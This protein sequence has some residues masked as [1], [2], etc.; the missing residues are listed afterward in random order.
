MTNQSKAS[1]TAVASN[2]KEDKLDKA[3]T[4]TV[5]ED[6]DVDMVKDEPISSYDRSLK[7]Q[8]QQT[9]APVTIDLTMTSDEDEDDDMEQDITSNPPRPRD[10]ACPASSTLVTS[11]GPKIVLRIDMSVLDGWK[12]LFGQL[13]DFIGEVVYN[14]AEKYWILKANTFRYMEG[15][16]LET[17][18]QTILLTRSFVESSSDTAS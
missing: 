10:I 1:K 7:Q 18:R 13:F 3:D 6:E 9:T 2:S 14:N 8:K 11:R 5:S 16:D 17:Y 12:P 15:L 4:Q